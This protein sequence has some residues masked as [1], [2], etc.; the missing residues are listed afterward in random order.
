[1]KIM[2]YEYRVKLSGVI[3]EVNCYKLQGLNYI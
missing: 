1:M 2:K 3:A